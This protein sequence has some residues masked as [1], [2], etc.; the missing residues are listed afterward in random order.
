[1]YLYKSILK[2]I[3]G[4]EEDFHNVLATLGRKTNKITFDWLT[5]KVS[6]CLNNCFDSEEN[7]SF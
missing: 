5:I 1:M 7:Y 3:C 4:S 6:N 2:A